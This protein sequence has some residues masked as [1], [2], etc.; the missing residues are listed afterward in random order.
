[1]TRTIKARF[2]HGVFE[3]L[4]PAVE[5]LVK[6]GEEVTITGRSLAIAFSSRGVVR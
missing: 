1:M 5:E 6:D 2:S 3:P 4:E